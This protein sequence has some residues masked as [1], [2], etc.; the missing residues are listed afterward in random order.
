MPMC[1]ESASHSYRRR[2][3]GKG[4]LWGRVPPPSLAANRCA[5]AHAAL[6]W[7]RSGRPTLSR[8]DGGATSGV[9]PQATGPAG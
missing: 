3:G 9:R 8:Q 6:E 4:G 7:E 5:S 1:T 2:P